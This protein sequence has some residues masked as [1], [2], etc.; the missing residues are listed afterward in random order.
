MTRAIGVVL[1]LALLGA[2]HLS[3]APQTTV[4]PAGADLVSTW[5]LTAWERS[6]GGGPAARVANPRGLLILDRAGNAFEFVTSLATQRGGQ[7]PLA[8]AQAAFAGYG[9]FWGQYRVDAAQRTMTYRAEHGLH[10]N[11]GGR[12]FSRSF[13]L[14]DNRLTITSI[15]EP[16][17]PVGTRWTWER[18]PPIDNLS[19]LY[20]NVVGF[21][22]H[23]VEK[24]VNPAT[25]A[26][27]AE[28]RRSPSVIVYTPAGFVGV[29]FPPLNRKPFTA[30]APTPEEAQAALRGYIGYY[31]ALTVYPGQVFHNILGGVSPVGG[32]ILRRSAEINGDELVVQLPRTRNQQG[33]EAQTVVVL[34]RLSGAADMLPR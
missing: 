13:V 24:R 18:V 25:G 8:E 10:P 30:D 11:L 29:H 7:V 26:S 21:W 33:D 12:E 15:A 23:I 22:R 3:S 2:A 1:V 9:G 27:G 17:T 31:G 5:T 4:Q 34:K 20:R 19:P 16:N 32:S 6:A 28:T 14:D